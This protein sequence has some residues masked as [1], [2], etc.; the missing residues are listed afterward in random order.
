MSERK[1]IE[2]SVNESKKRRIFKTGF[3]SGIGWAFGV[4]IGFAIIATILIVVLNQVNTL[5]WFG[6]TLADIIEITQEQ[7]LK[8]S[9]LNTSDL[10]LPQPT[11]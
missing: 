7:L 4:T 5:P 10:Q 11:P 1:N 9:I 6:E 8:R 3:V 2:N